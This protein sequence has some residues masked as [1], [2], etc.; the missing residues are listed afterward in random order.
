MRGLPG[1]GKSTWAMKKFEELEAANRTNPK[2]G[3]T[4]RY[5]SAD[6]FH[7]VDGVYQFNPTR[8]AEAHA[9][10]LQ[11]FTDSLVGIT[12]IHDC[13]DYELGIMWRRTVIVDNTNL[14]I[15]DISPYYRL[16]QAYG[17]VPTIIWFQTDIETCISRNIH[18]VQAKTIRTMAM[19]TDALPV[20]WNV[21]FLKGEA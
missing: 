6:V 7:V 4:V 3:G 5:H 21:V 10:C 1:S 19:R 11:N 2:K 16:A 15:E 14:R 9:R 13:A 17:F 20:D 12:R 8:V 18:N